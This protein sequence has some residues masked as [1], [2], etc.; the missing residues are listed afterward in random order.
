MFPPAGHAIPVS[1]SGRLRDSPLQ[2]ADQDVLNA[3]LCARPEPGR[4]LALEHRLAPEP[5]FPGL[6]LR[7]GDALG[8]AYDDGSEPYALHHLGPKPWLA[9]MRD[10]PYSRLLA[11]LLL[12]PGI[13]VKVPEADYRCACG[14]ARGRRQP[15][16][17]GLQDRFRS[18][19][20]EPLSW[21]IG[22][23]AEALRGRLT[24][25]AGATEGSG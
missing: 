14:G 4:I 10:G 21:R 3:V 24:R 1:S 16:L 5:P 22:A 18:S 15:G 23:W 25:S 8:C 6:R 11:R 2:L 12:G 7:G 17:A 9:P 13:E 20:R 19:V